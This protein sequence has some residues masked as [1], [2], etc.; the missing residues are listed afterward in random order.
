MINGKRSD[1]DPMCLICDG[2]GFLR[3]N[4][5]PERT[6]HEVGFCKCWAGR[7]SSHYQKRSH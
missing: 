6:I 1:P 2:S 4:D 5:E 7:E 3:V